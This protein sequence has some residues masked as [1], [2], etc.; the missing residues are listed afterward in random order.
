M[1][2]KVVTIRGLENHL[3]GTLGQSLTEEIKNNEGE[4]KMSEERRCYNCVYYKASSKFSGWCKDNREGRKTI[5][6][7]AVDFCDNFISK[8]R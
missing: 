8:E 3:P 7:D 6:S 5:R 4:R 2:N 1:A